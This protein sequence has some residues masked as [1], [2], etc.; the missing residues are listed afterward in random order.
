MA[1]QVA[2]TTGHVQTGIACV[3]GVDAV[4]RVAVENHTAARLLDACPL[5]LQVGL[6]VASKGHT[7]KGRF[8]GILV[9]AEHT[10]AVCHVGDGD[11]VLG[12]VVHHECRGGA[13]HLC[14]EFLHS[15]HR[16]HQ[17]LDLLEVIEQHGGHVR[18]LEAWVAKDELG[19]RVLDV[20]RHIV[21]LLAVAVEDAVNGEVSVDLQDH[22][23]VLVGA[24]G[25]QALAAGVAEA[26]RDDVDLV[27]QV[28]HGFIGERGLRLVRLRADGEP[29][30]AGRVVGL[31]QLHDAGSAEGGD[32][33]TVLLGNV[34]LLL[35]S[36][37][38]DGANG[39]AATPRRSLNR[40]G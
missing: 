24:L 32:E 15:V 1:H 23:R 26:R 19:E 9:R 10:G 27:S 7:N 8:R 18:G 39:E 37:V 25:L 31:E 6:V 12:V 38:F 4:V 35:R 16:H 29:A 5:V 34:R 21:P 33:S 20:L 3:L 22:P 36:R 2:E 14:A 13:R 17:A 40:L 28:S 30:A 11:L